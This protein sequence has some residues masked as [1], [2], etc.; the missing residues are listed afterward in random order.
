M[1]VMRL[2]YAHL[3]VEDLDAARRHYADTLGL[4]VSA[5]AGDLIHLKGWD[6]FDHHSVVLEEGGTGLARLGFKCETDDDLAVYEERA[7]AFGVTVERMGR[8]DN[9][10]VGDGLR[11]TLPSG[12]IVE[13]YREMEYVGTDVGLLNP[14]IRP[15]H[16]QGVDVPRLDHAAI[17]APEPA[18]VERFFCEVLGFRAPAR[19]ISDPAEAKL[20][21]SF[22]YCGQA[23]HDIAVLPGPPGGLSHIAFW[24]DDWNAILNAGDI[25]ALD[26]IPVEV[27]PSRHGI[28]RALTSY[29]FDPAGNRNEVQTGSYR[30]YADTP[31]V[32]WTADQLAKGVF[33]IQREFSEG[34]LTQVT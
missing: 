29:F 31:T 32:T 15:R 6:E 16:P 11:V 20:L 22:L 18:D 33:Y 24:V 12:Q 2:G 9:L 5:V 17:T 4:R 19:L 3:R 7:R 21:A 28:G 26:G 27:G 25:F 10:A 8:G 23:M 34:F 30:T 14:E 13:L 1:S